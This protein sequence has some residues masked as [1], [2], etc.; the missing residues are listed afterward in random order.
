VSGT[1]CAP[2]PSSLQFTDGFGLAASNGAALAALTRFDDDTAARGHVDI[3]PL[4]PQP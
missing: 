2:D 4:A 3:V 1:P